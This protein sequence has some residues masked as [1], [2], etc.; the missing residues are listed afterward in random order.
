MRPG[1]ALPSLPRST[2]LGLAGVAVALLLGLKEIP[3]LRSREAPTSV[4]QEARAAAVPGAAAAGMPATAAATGAGQET[5]AVAPRDTGRDLASLSYDRE[6]FY[7]DG[8]GRRDPFEPLLDVDVPLEGPRFDE[9]ALTGVFLDEE[10]SGMVVVE[11]S[12]RKGYFLR[13]GDSVGKATLIAIDPDE[14][15]FDVRDF[16]V[17]RRE[18]L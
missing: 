18:T 12:D 15:V 5:G 14:A 17:T 8:A 16:R 13:V 10:G 9:L 11:D 7:Y 4:S 1:T 6:F 2:L 3:G